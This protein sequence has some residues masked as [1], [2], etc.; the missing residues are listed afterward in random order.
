MRE[1]AEAVPER[2][3][4]PTV[5]FASGEEMRTEISAKFSPARVRQELVAAGM[6]PAGAWTDPTGDYPL[7][8]A[9]PAA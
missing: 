8:L 6:H 4:T 5:V 1:D 3:D 2:A 9:E 7:I